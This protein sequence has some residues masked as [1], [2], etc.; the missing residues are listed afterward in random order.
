[1]S[2]RHG[3]FCCYW[4]SKKVFLICTHERNRFLTVYMVFRL[5]NKQLAETCLRANLT[6]LCFTK[7]CYI[8]LACLQSSGGKYSNCV[9]YLL[10][11]YVT[12]LNPRKKSFSNGAIVECVECQSLNFVAPG[13]NSGRHGYF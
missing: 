2:F 4:A 6:F 5:L 1:M 10:F 11:Y 9:P 8:F 7:A 12:N 3:K 13:S